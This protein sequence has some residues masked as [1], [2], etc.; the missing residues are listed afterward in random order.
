M[1]RRRF[2][3]K[4]SGGVSQRVRKNSDARRQPM[5][6]RYQTQQRPTQNNPFDK[7]NRYHSG[8]FKEPHVVTTRGGDQ[9]QHAQ[10]Y[11]QT[12]Q[13]YA[14]PFVPRD[15]NEQYV[16]RI[17]GNQMIVQPDFPPDTNQLPVSTMELKESEHHQATVRRRLEQ[18]NRRPA[19][20]MTQESLPRAQPLHRNPRDPA[21]RFRQQHGE[22]DH[23]NNEPYNTMRNNTNIYPQPPPSGA[24]YQDQI[25]QHSHQYEMNQHA[26]PHPQYNHHQPPPSQP[27]MPNHFP[28]STENQSHASSRQQSKARDGFKIPHAYDHDAT[29]ETYNSPSNVNYYPKKQQQIYHQQNLQQYHKQN[30]IKTPQ[31]IHQKQYTY[32]TA[33]QVPPSDK[34]KES[35]PLKSFDDEHFV[36]PRTIRLNQQQVDILSAAYFRQAKKKN[37]P[38]STT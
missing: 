20:R 1:P 30:P 15:G 14:T 33:N 24:E 17:G 8:D 29:V 27:F 13:R 22:Y 5:D 28:S 11:P 26:P 4:G 2:K 6:P 16:R 38:T 36:D 7:G 19:S 23:H 25:Q 12:E 9:P 32:P 34:S 10:Y 21:D 37:V 31:Q 3:N 35:S 18:Q